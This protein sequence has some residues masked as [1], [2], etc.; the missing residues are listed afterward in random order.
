MVSALRRGARGLARCVPGL[1]DLQGTV[2]K[3]IRTTGLAICLALASPVAATVITFD[4]FP[5]DNF[6]GGLPADRYSSLGVTID[7]PEDGATRGGISNGDPGNWG[8]DGTN[9]PIFSGFNETYTMSLLF[10]TDIMS[11]SLDASRTNGSIDGT[12]TLQAFLDGLLVG[13]DGGDLGAINQWSTFSLSGLFDQITITGTGSGF[14][15]FGIDN[16]NFASDGAVPEPAT[17]AMM[18]LGFG[19]VGFAMRRERNSSKVSEQ[20]A[21]RSLPA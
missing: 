18:L 3:I 9:G 17:W 4:E 14:H 21:G 16:I 13:T 8:V 19:A 5:A 7:A 12:I 11:F 20:P 15:P 6:N 1:T 2:M 10:G